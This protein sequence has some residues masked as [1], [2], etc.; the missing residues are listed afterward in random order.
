MNLTAGKTSS[1]TAEIRYR[2]LLIAVHSDNLPIV[3]QMASWRLLRM[4]TSVRIE[5]AAYLFPVCLKTS[6]SDKDAAVGTTGYWRDLIQNV[7][8]QPHC[9]ADE[10]RPANHVIELR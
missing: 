2:L 1:A 7:L 6:S 8:A 3:D 10:D 5:H 4:S 9:V